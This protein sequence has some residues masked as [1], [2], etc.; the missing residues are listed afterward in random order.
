VNKFKKV[1]REQQLKRSPA[2]PTDCFDEPRGKNAMFNKQHA[3]EAKGKPL[4]GTSSLRNTL[5][6]QWDN[7]NM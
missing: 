1:K 2:R 7:A 6:R 5:V 4:M 3:C